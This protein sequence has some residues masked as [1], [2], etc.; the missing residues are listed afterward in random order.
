MARVAEA[1]PEVVECET[2]DVRNSRHY[3]QRYQMVPL[4][5]PE[6]VQVPLDP[7]HEPANSVNDRPEREKNEISLVVV[8][9]PRVRPH[10]EVVR[11]EDV[12]PSTDRKR[13]TWRTCC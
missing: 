2:H 9:N 3:Q 10:A 7:K 1:V 5:R 13:R 8:A 4:E 12:P 6:Q 11:A